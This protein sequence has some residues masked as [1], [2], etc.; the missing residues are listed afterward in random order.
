M[1]FFFS[2]NPEGKGLFLISQLG[3]AVG[4]VGLAAR[5][6]VGVESECHPP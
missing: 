6:C 4:G 1:F 2:P 5:F 3:L